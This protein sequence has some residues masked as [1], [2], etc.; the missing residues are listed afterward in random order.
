MKADPCM[1][2]D[3]KGGRGGTSLV[4]FSLLPIWYSVSHSLRLSIMGGGNNENQWHLHRYKGLYSYGL[5]PFYQ[6]SIANGQLGAELK[7]LGRGAWKQG[8]RM[9]PFVATIVAVVCYG[10]HGNW[11]SHRKEHAGHDGAS[12]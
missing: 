1:Y 6:N 5:S 10:N 4:I 8:L 9:A 3:G 11:L 7:A 12:H 2:D